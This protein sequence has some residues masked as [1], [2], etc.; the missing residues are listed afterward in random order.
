MNNAFKSSLNN[1]DRQ[2][3]DLD[4][5][6]FTG[7]LDVIF[8]N[9]NL[10]FQLYFCLGRIVWAD[11]GIHPHRSWRRLI[12]KYCF[13]VEFSHEDIDRSE[14]FQCWNY[15]LLSILLESDR[16]N[17]DTFDNFVRAKIEEVIFDL[18]QLSHLKESTYSLTP[19]S[20]ESL[21]S[22]GLKISLTLVPIEQAY[23]RALKTWLQWRDLSLEKTSPNLAPIVLDKQRLAREVSAQAYENLL[24]VI[25][26][27]HT[28]RDLAV[29]M[30]KDLLPLTVSLMPY[31]DSGLF[32]LNEIEDISQSSVTIASKPP[33]ETYT[34]EDDDRSD[35]TV[36]CIDD[37]PQA[38]GVMAEIISRA[39]FN[40]ISIQDPLQ[41]IPKLLLSSPDIVFLDIGMPLMNGYEVC[42]QLRRVPELEK[43]PVVML[44]GKD[45]VVDR[46]RAKIAGASG[47]VSKPIKAV[48]I[49]H[50]VLRFVTI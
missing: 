1:L 46:V 24:K 38:L 21:I 25:D 8:S 28:L 37:S 13:E 5:K 16:I 30:N 36:A 26:G 43:I 11:G 12:A 4:R 39:G 42:A 29:L 40:F 7:K 34:F 9:E 50:S 41:A 33:E 2:I 3:T 23:D 6:Q 45:G 44:T 22:S 14:K 19:T 20:G 10:Q 31:L 18:I 48:R 15:Q 27:Y 49:L 17:Y 35:I 32:Q 47:F